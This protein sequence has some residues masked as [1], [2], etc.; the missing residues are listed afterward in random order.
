MFDA[1][2]YHAGK[3]LKERKHIQNLFMQNKLRII[4]AT[5]SFGM[6]LDKSDVRAVIHFNLPRSV[7]NYVQ[8]IG[9]AG[10]DGKDAFCHLFLS[11]EDF[12][13]IQSFAYSETVDH[14]TVK[15]LLKKIFQSST[16]IPH[17]NALQLD[18]LEIDFDMKQEVI[19]TIVSYLEL[20]K[21]LQLLP[22]NTNPSF[23]LFLAASTD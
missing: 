8:E 17:F 15:K 9:R 21:Y 16:Q 11:Q 3:D 22:S 14:I 5:V 23:F 6:G 2:S 1:A 4:V 19:S 20:E 13:T 10:R 7:E 18:K 12:Y